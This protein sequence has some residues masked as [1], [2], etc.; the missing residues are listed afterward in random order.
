MNTYSKLLMHL[1]RHVYK[2]GQ[3]KGDAPA[4]RHKRGKSFFRVVKMGTYMT[5][6]MHGTDILT[7]YPDG[8]IVIDTAGWYD[9]STTRLR[10]NEALGFVGFGQ[11]YMRKVMGLSQPVFRAG[12]NSYRYYDGME[13]DDSAR[14]LTK[15]EPFEMRRIDKAE[16]KEFMDAV[17][18]SGF[19]D[20]FPLLYANTTPG[21][22][23][24]HRMQDMITDSDQAH[25]WPDI[26]SAYKFERVYN[27]KMGQHATLERG[28]AKTCWNAIMKECK[29]GMYVTLKSDITTI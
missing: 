12:N 23:A 19:K 11:I 16:T 18:A 6:R 14:L 26:I 25:R 4:D 24:V 22:V 8:R 15:A 13:F 2:R 9:S 29:K 20:M 3:Y 5:V 7:A 17:K 27:Y 21:P 10:L 1:E 28:T